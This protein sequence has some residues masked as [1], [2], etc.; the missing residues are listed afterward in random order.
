MVGPLYCPQFFKRYQIL[1]ANLLEIFLKFVNSDVRV[2]KLEHFSQKE[3]NNNKNKKILFI[4][5]CSDSPQL[6]NS[7]SGAF[8]N[9]R[10][11]ISIQ[12][13]ICQLPQLPT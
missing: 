1:I 3:N 10:T 13:C 2:N 12:G 9:V 5:Y 6:S 11:H 4:S 7:Y 8:I